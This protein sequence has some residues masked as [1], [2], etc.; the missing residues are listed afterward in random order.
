MFTP[1]TLNNGTR[2]FLAPQ[3][4]TQAVTVLALFPVGS[5]YETAALNGASH[6]IE[7][8]AFK[9]TARRPTTLD[10]SRDLDR[11]GAEYNAFTGKDY[12]G[13]YIKAN[14]GHLDLALD[15]LADIC[16][17][18]KF[19]AEEVERER[20]VILEEI[21]LYEDNP[22]MR[23]DDL[24][25]ELIF[26]G[27]PLGRL[28][29]GTRETVNALKRPALLAY[30]DRFYRSDCCVLA[31]AGAIEDDVLD[32]IRG[33]FGAVPARPRRRGLTSQPFR[34]RPR[35]PIVQIH[36]KETAQAHVAIGVPA[37]T[38]DNPRQYPLAILANVLG[39]TMSS[40]L[41]IAVRERRALAYSVR[42][43]ADAYADT[44]YFAVTAGV[45][46]SRFMEAI[47]V[48]IGE[49][50]RVCKRGITAEELSRAQENIEG[51][52]ILGLEESSARADWYGRQALL[53]KE[54]LTP[55]EKIARL[56]SVDRTAVLRV[57]Q[58]ILR[59]DR[60]HLAVI[61]PYQ[62]GAEFKRLLKI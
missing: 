42:A 25:E 4:D 39:G 40:R 35:G 18:P 19:V 60:L 8:M 41:W 11:I 22:S 47:R 12:T 48:I 38:A 34:R 54:I 20:R 33:A 21:H 58:E 7:H 1:H 31:V 17:H 10:I 52:I 44:G 46:P 56:K 13:Y 26:R 28:I 9:G 50:S 55:A 27:H 24:F 16:F 32:R 49:L 43:S 62:D 30:R 53:R 3:H 36:Q 23:L 51:R 15:V 45:D 5:R 6:F 59:T 14:A 29:S 2:V 61:G 37:Y 57:A